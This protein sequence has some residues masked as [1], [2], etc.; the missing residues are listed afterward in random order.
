[1]ATAKKD[2]EKKTVKKTAAKAATK[3]GNIKG[4]DKEMK[5]TDANVD[6]EQP[7]SDPVGDRPDPHGGITVKPVD[8]EIKEVTN[9]EMKPTDANVD[10]EQPMGDPVG[11]RPDPHGG[12]TIKS[13]K[14]KEI[15]KKAEE[16]TDKLFH[17]NGIT[18]GNSEKKD[19]GEVK[20]VE[21]VIE[22]TR[23]NPKEE[24]TK[25]SIVKKISKMIQYMWNGQVMD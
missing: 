15:E 6:V 23:K 22:E 8:K 3:K 10:V 12:I 2:T 24:P 7:M 20:T 9:E 14:Q 5:P 16:E 11:D 21:D 17:S 13:A 25:P 19:E 1:M 18:L 4:P